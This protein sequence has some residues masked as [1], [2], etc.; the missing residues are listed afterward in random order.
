VVLSND[1]KFD[2][3]HTRAF[4]HSLDPVRVDLIGQT[5]EPE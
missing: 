4:L 2:P 1:P 3:R 5:E